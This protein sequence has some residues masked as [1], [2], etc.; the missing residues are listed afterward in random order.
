MTHENVQSSDEEIIA[1]LTSYLDGELDEAQVREV[2]DRIASD[3]RHQNL[4]R[5]LQQTWDVLDILPSAEI[6]KACDF[7]QSTMK[8]VVQ[9]AKKLTKK[10]S[11]GFW[12]WPFRVFA[13]CLVP[14][15]ASAGTFIT[16][17][18][19][20][21][22]PIRLLE[23][24]LSVIRNVDVYAFDK[25]LSIEF[26]EA[27]ANESDLFGVA[28]V[29]KPADQVEMVLTDDE[30]LDQF[31]SLDDQQQQRI[32]VNFQ[33]FRNLSPSESERIN[34]LHLKITS[35]T[36]SNELLKTM[37]K[38]HQWL[39]TLWETQTAEILDTV[40]TAS[41]IKL[42]K[43][44]TWQKYEKNFGTGPAMGLPPQD[45]ESIYLGMLRVVA[46]A[47]KQNQIE[48]EILAIQPFK[49]LEIEEVAKKY[50]NAA[51]RQEIFANGRKLHF[52]YEQ[53]P[54]II[55]RLFTEQDV[56]TI[57]GI[58]SDEAKDVIELTIDWRGNSDRSEAQLLVLWMIE[59]FKAEFPPQNVPKDI[60]GVYDDLKAEERD[61]IDNQLPADRKRMLLKKL[62]E[63]NWN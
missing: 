5:Q 53:A 31:D 63:S 1:Q 47:D 18:Y 55:D 15:F 34:N 57:K 17:R 43:D 58:L 40:S 54:E 60:Q 7:T 8:L 38:Y 28:S 9:D 30:L 61:W 56:Q 19:L 44:I 10:T 12:K 13:L 48:D 62:E 46:D 51:D 50:A 29:P 45:K 21:H 2:E 14:C 37:R 41:R 3:T 59:R 25:N 23:S 16:G 36:R 49:V 33:R 24:N 6:S 22:S 32:R 35:H 39:S 42:I 4:L 20:Q 52:L 27:L 11:G 26:L